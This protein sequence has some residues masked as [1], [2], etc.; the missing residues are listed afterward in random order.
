MTGSGVGSRLV[1]TCGGDSLCVIDCETGMVMKKYKVPGEVRPVG[2][3][4]SRRRMCLLFWLSLQL[5]FY[6]LAVA[7]K[8]TVFM[9]IGTV[10][11]DT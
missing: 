5:S 7:F 3:D 9:C 1:A 8:F 11:V 4:H 2:S 6:L 10:Y